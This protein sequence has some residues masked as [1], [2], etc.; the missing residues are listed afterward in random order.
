MISSLKR[1]HSPEAVAWK[2]GSLYEAEGPLK[3]FRFE[4][5]KCVA[6]LIIV[7]GCFFPGPAGDLCGAFCFKYGGVRAIDG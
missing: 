3:G 6:G 5:K 4:P 2:N 7:I 1:F